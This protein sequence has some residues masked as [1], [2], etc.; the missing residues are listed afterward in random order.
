MLTD[1]KSALVRNPATLA[2]DFA[3]AAALAVTLIAGL[4]LPGLF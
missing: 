1:V 2:L 3:G 4:F